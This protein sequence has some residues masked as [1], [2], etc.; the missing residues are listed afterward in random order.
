MAITKATSSVL[1]D[2]AALNNLNAGASIAFTKPVSVS[3]NL[4]VDTNTLFV[5]SVNDRVGIGTTTPTS[6]LHV[7]GDGNFSEDIYINSGGATGGL[8]YVGK[9]SNS[10]NYAGLWMGSNVSTHTT[11]NY[12]FLSDGNDTF[13]NAKVGRNVYFRIGNGTHAT[14]DSSGNFG[15]GTATPSAKLHAVGSLRVDNGSTAGALNFGADVQATTRSSDVRKLAAI[16]SPDYAN[17]RNIEWATSDSSS[18]AANLVSIGGRVGGSNYAATAITLATAPNVSTAGGTA[19]LHIDSSQRVGIG[20]TTPNNNLNVALTGSTLNKGIEVSHNT[21]GFVRLINA[22]SDASTMIPMIVGKGAA[23]N[24]ASGLIFN[25]QTA[26]DSNIAYGVISFSARNNAG[27]GVVGNSQRAIEFLNYTTSLMVIRGDG[28]VGVGATTPTSSFSR[29]LQITGDGSSAITLSNVAATKKYSFGLT[30]TNSLGFYDETASAYRLS[31]LTT[32]EVGIGTTTPSTKAAL[33]ITS[34]TKGF[35]PPRMTTIQRDAITSVPAGLV[36]Y[37]TTTSNLN[38]YNGSVWVELVDSSDLGTNIPTFLVDPSSENL[39]NALGDTNG[40]GPFILQDA[41]TLTGPNLEQPIITGPVNIIDQDAS[42]PDRLMNRSLSDARVIK[43]RVEGKARIFS[44]MNLPTVVGGSVN[45]ATRPNSV[46]VLITAANTHSGYVFSELSLHA[47]WSGAGFNF[48]RNFLCSGV[49]YLRGLGDQNGALR[50][51]IGAPSSYRSNQASLAT[52]GLCLEF[53]RNATALEARL[54]YFSG[55][56]QET[57]WVNVYN[58]GLYYTSVYRFVIRNTGNGNVAV[59][60]LAG[61]DTGTTKPLPDIDGT[62]IISITNG[63]TTTAGA[64]LVTAMCADSILTPATN[65]QARI[66]HFDLELLS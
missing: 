38:T 19:A 45:H 6:K 7:A 21:G 57:A 22:S 40:T 37:N 23:S 44:L 15:I 65:N 64:N 33:D 55:T 47:D 46:D 32:G 61:I 56:Y 3:D 12:S 1:A 29:T 42:T 63:P 2:N 25:G 27:T 54:S 11:S 35:L 49:F 30:S 28:N 8:V 66:Q 5:D 51:Y 41:A 60:F 34:T 10:A 24:H 31:I 20:T 13:F 14:L 62:P 58:T 52:A 53:R 17:T 18:A 48:A 43:N 36:I 26:N 4:T 50:F 59:Y 9:A 39:A 16:V